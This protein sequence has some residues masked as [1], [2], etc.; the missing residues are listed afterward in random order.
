MIFVQDQQKEGRSCWIIST[1]LVTTLQTCEFLHM[2]K[3]TILICLSSITDLSAANRR[4]GGEGGE[5]QGQFAQGLQCEGVPNSFTSSPVTFQSS[6]FKGLVSLHFQMLFLLCVLCC[7]CKLQMNTQLSYT[8][9]PPIACI[10]GLWPQ[11]Q[12]CNSL[13]SK[14]TWKF[15]A[16]QYSFTVCLLF[17]MSIMIN[18]WQ[19]MNWNGIARFLSSVG[20]VLNLHEY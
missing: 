14:A 6:F 18:L 10:V 16:H 12:L 11:L 4:G 1:S 20:K 17:E 5:Q 3:C 2:Q 13:F 15:S 9:N 19:L 7:W 8:A